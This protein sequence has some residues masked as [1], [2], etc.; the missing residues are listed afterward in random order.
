MHV[1]IAAVFRHQSLHLPRKQLPREIPLASVAWLR[2]AIK[3]NQTYCCDYR[4]RWQWASFAKMYKYV[5]NY[6]FNGTKAVLNSP[7][8]MQIPKKTYF[9]F[10]SMRSGEV[11]PGSSDILC[12]CTTQSPQLPVSHTQRQRE[13]GGPGCAKV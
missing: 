11:S 4:V 8:Q 2:A 3:G 12:F 7:A 9:F 5:C 13:L 10:P 6:P 1:P